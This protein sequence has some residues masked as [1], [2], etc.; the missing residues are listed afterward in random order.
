MV[1]IVSEKSKQV[2]IDVGGANPTSLHFHTGSKDN[3]DS[4]IARIGSSKA[5]A[6][7]AADSKASA[8]PIPRSLP[9]PLDSTRELP[10]KAS[11]HFSSADPVIIPVA[12]DA[13]SESEEEIQATVAVALYDFTADGDDE[14]SVKEGEVL[15]ILEK[16]GD[17]WW[18]CRNSKGKSGVVPASYLEV[19]SLHF[20]YIPISFFRNLLLLLLHTTSPKMPKRT[21]LPLKQ[22]LKL[23]PQHRLQRPQLKRRAGR[24]RKRKRRGKR[25]IA[26]WRSSLLYSRRQGKK[27]SRYKQSE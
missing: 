16:D 8:S 14:L 18:K 10:K 9:P 4:I 6:S 15:T 24:K 3:A 26:R 12:A 22:R 20:G 25:K 13:E 23:Q 17:E 19:R 5:I 7:A 21:T 1:E 11:V 2:R 27:P